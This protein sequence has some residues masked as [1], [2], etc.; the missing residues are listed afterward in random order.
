MREH[1]FMYSTADIAQVLSFNILFLSGFQARQ[2]WE[3]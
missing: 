2:K 1:I 3:E